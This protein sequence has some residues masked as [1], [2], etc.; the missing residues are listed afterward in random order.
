[1]SEAVE[2]SLCYFFK[3]RMMKHKN[4][5]L[6]MPLGTIIHQNSYFYNPFIAIFFHHFNMKHPVVRTYF[7][8]IITF[9]GY[10]RMSPW[11]LDTHKFEV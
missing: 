8:K 4:Q 3:K 1:L 9:G 7:E 2:A 11:E 10:V 5:N 6:L